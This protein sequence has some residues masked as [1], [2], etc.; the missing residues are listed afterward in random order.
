[1]RKLSLLPL[2][3]LFLGAVGAVLRTV[4]LGTVFD[5]ASGLPARGA[6]VSTALAALTAGVI[7][8]ALAV[9]VAVYMKKDVPVLFKKAFYTGNYLSFAV[10]AL[11]GI[12][13][14]GA[15]ALCALRYDPIMDLTDMARWVF[16]GFVALAGFGM[17]VMAYT[18][19]T[20][21][22]S[23]YLQ[24]GSVMPA[25]FY[26]YWMVAL[27]R[28]NA[29]NPVLI[30]Y[31]YGCMA[32]AAA[33]MSAYYTAGYTYKRKSVV[34]ST[35]VSLAAIYLLTVTLADGYILPLKLVIAATAVYLTDNTARFLS[36]LVPKPPKAPEGE[37]AEE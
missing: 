35:F 11:L 21:R 23:P 13:V 10:R 26:C 28:V 15:A 25:I 27:Y 34:G 12:L 36:A 4:E 31:C 37:D 14:I 24:L 29:G 17:T 6:P 20:Q 2:G 8:V 22:E 7:V 5:P 32:F 1:M 33:A 16:I 3:A 30:D 19:Y 18:S 9:S